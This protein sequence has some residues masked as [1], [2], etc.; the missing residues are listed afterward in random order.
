M[1]ALAGAQGYGD[2]LTDESSEFVSFLGEMGVTGEI[3]DDQRG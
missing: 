1:Q 3:K 2:T